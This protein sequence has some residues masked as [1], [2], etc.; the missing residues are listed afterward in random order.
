MKK[1]EKLLKS[2]NLEEY[3]QFLKVVHN[4]QENRF[5]DVLKNN[6]YK[7]EMPILP[8]YEVVRVPIEH[9]RP[10]KDCFMC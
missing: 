9:F 10:Y 7:G 3:N 2:Y 8:T 1:I 4:E 5:G 6:R